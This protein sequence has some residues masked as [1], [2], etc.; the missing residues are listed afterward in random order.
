MLSLMLDPRF[1][2]IHLISSFV[3]R[4]EGVSIVDEYDKSILYPML[5][6]CYHGLHPMI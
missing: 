1:K 4:E 2:S 6:K 3:G 5:L